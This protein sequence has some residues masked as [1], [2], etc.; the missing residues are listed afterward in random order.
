MRARYNVLDRPSRCRSGSS[1]SLA[2]S[3]GG[4]NVRC[5][6]RDGFANASHNITSNSVALFVDWGL[7]H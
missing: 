4:G 2:V 3:G 1:P 6:F 5:I 7:F